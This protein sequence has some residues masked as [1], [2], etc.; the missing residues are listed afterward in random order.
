MFHKLQSVEAW[1][2]CL[3]INSSLQRLLPGLF[4]LG[5][6]ELSTV[7]NIFFF[8]FP[9]LSFSL[10]LCPSNSSSILSSILLFSSSLL[11]PPFLVTSEK[12]RWVILSVPS[13]NP[14]SCAELIFSRLLEWRRAGNAKY[15]C[16]C[17]TRPPIYIFETSSPCALVVHAGIRAWIQIRPSYSSRSVSIHESW[18]WVSDSYFYNFI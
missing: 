10:S 15:P 4:T 7:A 13:H 8:I 16:R 11:W 5:F 6:C 1:S 14:G 17:L 9:L 18:I 12:R 3:K 2:T